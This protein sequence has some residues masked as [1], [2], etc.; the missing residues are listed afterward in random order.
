MSAEEILSQT[1]IRA[2][3][4]PAALHSDNVES[5]VME[6]EFVRGSLDKERLAAESEVIATFDDPGSLAD[7]YMLNKDRGRRKSDPVGISV[8]VAIVVLAMLLV[9][10]Y[11]HSSRESLAAYGAFNQTLGPVYRA[12]GNP[13]TPEWDVKGWQFETTRGSTSDEGGLLTIFSRISNASD[14]PLPYPLVHV[15]LT[16]RWEEIIGSKVLEPADYLAGELDP[17]K[18]VAPGDRFSAVIAIDSPSPEATGFKLNV[19]YRVS[20]GRVRCATE[21]FK[22]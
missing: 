6:G 7:T 15:S 17:R 18:P 21:D 11:V 10:Q 13:I 16:D 1:M 14:E 12:L 9:A 3:I 20:P 8:I 19:C 2:G 22:D 4:D 5:I